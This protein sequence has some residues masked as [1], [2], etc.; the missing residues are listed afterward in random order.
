MMEMKF[1]YV[2]LYVA[3][4]NKTVAFYESAFGLKRRMVHESRY[5][6]MDTGATTLAFAAHAAADGMGVEYRRTNPDSPPPA[7]EIALVSDDV[8]VAYQRAVSAGATPIAPPKEKPWGQTVAYVRELDG[9][10]V[11]LC[12]PVAKP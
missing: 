5:A 9:F 12:S 3:D 10:L 4:I 1:G 11:E 6:E 7:F 2:L 8:S